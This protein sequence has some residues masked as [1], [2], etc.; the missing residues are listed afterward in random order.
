MYRVTNCRLPVARPPYLVMW[1]AALLVFLALLAVPAA[2]VRAESPGSVEGANEPVAPQPSTLYL[3]QVALGMP[4][5]ARSETSG[6]PTASNARY[7]AVPVLG[8]AADRP[9]AVHADLNLAV[10]SY[11]TT[12]APLALVEING[13]TDW[14]P[15]QLATLFPGRS[16]PQIVGAYRVNGWDWGCVDRSDAPWY[17]HGCRAAP[18]TAPPVTLLGLGSSRGEQ[19]QIPSRQAEISP[20]MTALVL[21]AEETRL[22]L[23]YT[24]E[25]TAAHGYV[26][27]IEDICVDANLLAL[28]RS[29]NAAGRSSLPGLRNGDLAG[30]AS[31]SAIKVAVRDTGSFMDPR[32]RKD[33]WQID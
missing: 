3:P 31:G 27:H 12:T 13:A 33:W 22:T 32:S 24:L 8:P 25:D 14:D 29:L 6:C 23:G 4:S 18:I 20:G 7:A 30:V 17:G 1:I 28:Y 19:V 15:P 16:R 21:Y 10:R 2:A 5:S 9:P 26:V 11:T